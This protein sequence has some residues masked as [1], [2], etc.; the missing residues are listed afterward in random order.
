MSLD[1]R[2]RLRESGRISDNY[3]L[4]LEEALDWWITH[5]SQ[6]S[7][8]ELVRAVDDCGER[9]IAYEMRKKLNMEDNEYGMF[10]L[11]LLCFYE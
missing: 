6:P 5:S 10:T 2:K 1:E 9:N 8:E 3:N 4:I 11:I 7:W